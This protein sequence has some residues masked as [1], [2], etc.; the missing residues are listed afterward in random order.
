VALLALRSRLLTHPSYYRLIQIRLIRSLPSLT[1]AM[2]VRL[3]C[4]LQSSIPTLPTTGLN[5][6]SLIYNGNSDSIQLP[7]LTLSGTLNLSDTGTIT[8]SGAL[9]ITGTTTLSAATGITLTTST[10][11]F[12]GAL[13]INDTGTS[14]TDSVTNNIATSLATSNVAGNP[15]LARVLT[16]LR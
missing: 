3:I 13:S 7:A 1:M 4:N 8:Q 14:S 11:S 16:R 10:N 6:L 12:T 9:A 5:N 15:L 2:L